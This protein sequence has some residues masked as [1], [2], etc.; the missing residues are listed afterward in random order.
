MP[1]WKLTIEDDEGQKTVVPLV[2][3]EYT[4][5]RRDGHT[6]RL[7]ERNV[8]RD[9]A[10]IKKDGDAYALEDLGSYNGV[11]VNGH[12]VAEPVKIQNGDLILIGDYRLE[13][14]NEDA[15]AVVKPLP[16]AAPPK[17]G[18]SVVP[19]VAKPARVE[20]KPHRFVLLTGAEGGKE[21]PLDKP[22]MTIGRGEEVDIRVN[23]SSVSRTHCEVHSAD[24]ER[25]EVVD[26]ESA[27]GIRVNGQD[28]KR[29]QLAAGD[30]LELGDVRLKYIAAGQAYAF[31]ATAA[32]AHDVPREGR[33]KAGGAKW[34]ILVL[35]VAGAAIG[36]VVLAKQTG[37]G[38][39][40]SASAVT[41]APGEEALAKAYK[42]KQD[43]DAVAAHAQI[44]DFDK[45]SPLRKD[46]RF[47]EIENAWADKAIASIKDEPDADKRKR[48]L[49]DVLQSGADESFRTTAANML[50]ELD[51]PPLP[52]DT[53]KSPD[54]TA[55]HP[56]VVTATPPKTATPPPTPPPPGATTAKTP[57]T[58]TTTAPPKPTAT[59]PATAS[60]PT[61]GVCPSY[62][63]AYGEAIKGGD[64]GCVRTILLP[65]LNAGTIGSNEAKALKAACVQLGDS[66]CAKRA[67]EKI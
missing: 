27:N 6:I 63:G 11:F 38:P 59:T 62:K 36:G 48:V 2:R 32:E 60:T 67:A 49:T 18:P 31:D 64:W 13:A 16:P 58:A 26:N 51:T 7:T 53:V 65:K 20:T 66:A 37:D 44:K 17:P 10:A 5:G 14:H 46:K 34:A 52:S 45:A 29:A 24:Q 19:P 28:V 12:R 8:S 54:P 23:H 40:P 39:A 56:T 57:P 33:R 43:G 47:V 41:A 22:V 4:I 30:T 3:D 42:T 9:H 15:P 21:Y 61:T 55:T 35:C 50:G 1:I 25:F